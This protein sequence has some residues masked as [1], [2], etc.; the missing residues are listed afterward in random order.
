MKTVRIIAAAF[1]AL[2]ATTA[3]A[4]I[5]DGSVA[6]DFTAT[7]INGNTVSLQEFMDAGKTVIMD[8]SATWC[9]PCWS[10]HQSGIL[11]TFYE[12]FGPEGADVATVIYVEGDATTTL[13][14]IQGTGSNTLGDWTAGVNYP[15]VDDADIAD[16][17]EI[18]YFPTIF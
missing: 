1:A 3:S 12:M 4:Q 6:P 5:A 16:D 8:V 9:P 2:F 14:D 18:T 11:E 10:Y 15:I 13:E 17:Y 7:D